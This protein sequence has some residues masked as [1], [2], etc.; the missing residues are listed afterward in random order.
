MSVKQFA[1]IEALQEEKKPSLGYVFTTSVRLPNGGR[2]VVEGAISETEM[3][4][5]VHPKMIVG[6][7]LTA[8]AV[9]IM[10]NLKTVGVLPDE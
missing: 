1:A 6:A 2:I 10:E 8:Q 4:Y 5:A 7:T 3:K 9:K